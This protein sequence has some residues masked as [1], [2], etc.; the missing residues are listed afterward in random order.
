MRLTSLRCPLDANTEARCP[1]DAYT[2][3]RCSCDAPTEARRQVSQ[4]K[5][6]SNCDKRLI[7]QN[8]QY[9]NKVYHPLMAKRPVLVFIIIFAA[10]GSSYLCGYWQ[11]GKLIKYKGSGQM[12]ILDPVYL[13]SG[14]CLT[15]PTSMRGNPISF[16]SSCIT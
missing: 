4:R 9:Y 2:E 1:C 11:S 10:N 6:P 3:A 14:L 13:G 15:S 7:S 16:S 8:I 12:S 5:K